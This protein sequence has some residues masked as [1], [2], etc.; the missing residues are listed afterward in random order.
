MTLNDP[1]LAKII[2]NSIAVEI[3][4]K[5][6]TV[7]PAI[8]GRCDGCYFQSKPKC[9]TKAVNMCTSNNGNIFKLKE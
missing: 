5:K 4:N 8:G 1:E 2:K 3:D 6:F 7:E 9:P